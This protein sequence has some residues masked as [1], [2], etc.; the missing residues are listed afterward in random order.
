MSL[1]KILSITGKPGL[2]ELQSQTKSGF[3]A[4]SLLDGKRI[5]V[6]IRHNVSM[7][8]EIAIYTYTEEIP[9]KDI[10]NTIQEK[11][12]GQTSVTHKASEKEL[13]KYFSE[14]LPNY[15]EERV[16]GSDIKKVIKWYNMLEN[17]NLLNTTNTSEEE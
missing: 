3:I 9:L 14:I 10:F 7:L 5:S 17:K 8:S 2:Y 16:Y 15:D 12:N 11:E 6:G 1:E 4:T 13:K